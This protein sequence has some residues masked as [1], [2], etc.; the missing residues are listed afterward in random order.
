MLSFLTF[1]FCHT[2]KQRDKPF[3]YL[4]ED[5]F[6]VPGVGTVISGLVTRGEWKKGESIY[7]GPLRDGSIMQMIPKSVHVAQT[8]VN[9][10]YAG[11]SVCFALPKISKDKRKMFTK[12]MVALKESFVPV[13]T[14]TAQVV[15]F[16]GKNTTIQNGQY[17]STLNI[18]HHK[19]AAKVTEV[20]DSGGNPMDVTRNN[21]HG[22]QR[23]SEM[24]ITFKLLHRPAYLRKG[25]KIIMRD[26]HV[27]GIGV[28]TSVGD[29]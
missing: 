22:N 29:N 24:T 13:R 16:K 19:V 14:L 7:L 18:L 20:R 28:I 8:S 26:G 17:Q 21:S 23:N 4:V 27:R 3:E 11:H 6:Q 15:L 1:A 9:H 10:V 25:M 12:G 5:I 2:Q